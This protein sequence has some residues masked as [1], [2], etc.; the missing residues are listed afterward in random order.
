MKKIFTILSVA[1]CSFSAFS[2]LVL[3]QSNYPVPLV[4]TPIANFTS[5]VS[6]IPSR[7]NNQIWDYTTGT[8]SSTS[9]ND[10][11]LLTND[12]N[13][14][15]AQYRYTALY[16]AINSNFG[17][18]YDQYYSI[19]A[20]G[21]KAIGIRIPE[22]RYGLGLLT[23]NNADSL[24][25]PE[26][27]I[28]YGA[29]PRPLINFPTNLNDTWNSTK[30]N[31][32]NMQLTVTSAGLTSAPLQQVFYFLRLDSVIGN[33][34]LKLPPQAGYQNEIPVVQIKT[35]SATR[36]SF[37]LNGSLAPAQLMTGFG[38][39]QNQQTAPIGFRYNFYRAGLNN[40]QMVV[41][42]SD[43]NFT[44]L[45]SNSAYISTV[46]PDL[47][48]GIATVSSGSGAECY[49][50]PVI[51]NNCLILTDN[52]VKDGNVKLYDVS[53]REMVV[54]FTSTG[55]QRFELQWNGLSAGS[56]TYVVSHPDGKVA[57]TGKIMLLR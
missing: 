42:F 57:A 49:P 51:G 3:T 38:L 1:G 21:V 47:S 4:S 55:E 6:S 24:I 33:G 15:T 39:T 30:R 52:S 26:D 56:Y 11:E 54:S 2:Q 50:N 32:V 53:G 17:F 16:K 12:P 36:D 45:S 46:Y 43:P 28:D 29:D 7:G 8:P 48:N 20:S 27:F 14:P 25:I 35:L 13:F 9:P 37:Y 23:G 44:T 22:Q 31:V 34:I 19:E 5:A 18:N 40:Y 41:N 10:A